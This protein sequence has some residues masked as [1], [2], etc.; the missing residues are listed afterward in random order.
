[1]IARLI[2]STLALLLFAGAAV[3]QTV[4]PFGQGYAIRKPGEPTISVQPDGRGGWTSIQQGRPT[5]HVDP[6]PSPRGGTEYRVWSSEPGTPAT[7]IPP[8]K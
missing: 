2:L 8:R 5:M 1:M 4:E 3:A 7:I 6:Q